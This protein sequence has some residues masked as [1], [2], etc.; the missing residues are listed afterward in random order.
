[1]D[2]VASIS[3]YFNSRVSKINSFLHL[4]YGW[5][6]FLYFTGYATIKVFQKLA[7]GNKSCVLLHIRVYMGKTDRDMDT[8]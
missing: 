1:M 4:L 3:V 5:R 7:G 8:F 6:V 2:P